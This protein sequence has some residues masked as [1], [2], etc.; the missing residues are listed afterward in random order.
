MDA[1]TTAIVAAVLSGAHSHKEVESGQAAGD[2]VDRVRSS[3]QALK[4]ALD[5]RGI[6]NPG[7]LGLPSAFGV[8]PR[9]RVA[10]RHGGPR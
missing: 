5:P 7:K 4:E 6:L 9:G 1:V 8:G 2:E 3:Y 10:D